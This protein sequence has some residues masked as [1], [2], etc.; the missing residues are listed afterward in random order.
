M[1]RTSPPLIMPAWSMV[2]TVAL[3]KTMGRPAVKAAVDA[4]ELTR[5]HLVVKVFV[6]AAGPPRTRSAEHG[7]QRLPQPLGRR[8]LRGGCARMPRGDVEVGAY[9]QQAAIL[10]FAQ[11][12][13][14]PVG[15]FEW[16]TRPDRHLGDR[17]PGL[18]LDRGR[19]IQPGLPADAGPPA[20]RPVAARARGPQPARPAD[21]G[22]PAER[23]VAGEIQ[24]RD[25][26]PGAGHPGVRQ[27]R[28]GPGGRLGIE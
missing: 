3:R 27:L 10:D 2:N 21:A 18:G 4:S 7:L 11:L 1:T 20:D 25:P 13:P 26:V 22:P 28:A 5:T 8:R 16:L 9:Q 6:T 19:G 24:R 23:P 15:V 17:Q 14:G 12:R